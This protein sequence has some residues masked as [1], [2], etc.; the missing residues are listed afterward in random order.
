MVGD[1]IKVSDQV[2]RSAQRVVAF[3]Y[4]Y[5]NDKSR[6]DNVLVVLTRPDLRTVCQRCDEAGWFAKWLVFTHPCHGTKAPDSIEQMKNSIDFQESE[7]EELCFVQWYEIL[8]RKQLPVDLIDKAFDCVK[9]RLQRIEGD[10]NEF[11]SSRQCGLIPVGSIK[12]FVHLVRRDYLLYL[13]S[14][15]TTQKTR[16]EKITDEE[17]GSLKGTYYVSRFTRVKLDI[18]C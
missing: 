7:K 13:V 6:I 15:S 5:G 11:S 10:A 3:S 14:K 18:Q 9:L 2:L 8:S 4:F 16:H 17:T 1:A 12:E